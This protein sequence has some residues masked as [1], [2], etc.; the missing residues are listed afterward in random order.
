MM[1]CLMP[2]LALRARDGAVDIEGG[3]RAP[4]PAGG[5]IGRE[6]EAAFSTREMG[7]RFVGG[8]GRP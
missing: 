6:D 4:L 1:P 7:R 3:A 5:L 8:R 2:A